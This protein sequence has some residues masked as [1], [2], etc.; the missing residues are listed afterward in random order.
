MRQPWETGEPVQLW[1][2]AAPRD[3][4]EGQEGAEPQGAGQQGQWSKNKVFI[5]AAPRHSVEG[6]WA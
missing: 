6:A 4:L 3:Q 1:S 5:H 2:E